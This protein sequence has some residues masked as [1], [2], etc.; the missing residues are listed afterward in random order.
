MDRLSQSHERVSSLC[1]TTKQY[2]FILMHL[3]CTCFYLNVVFFYFIFS[4]HLICR[5][6]LALTCQRVLT[7]TMHY[8]M[9]SYYK[10]SV[11]PNFIRYFQ[12]M[13]ITFNKISHSNG[14]FFILVSFFFLCSCSISLRLISF[15]CLLVT[16][17]TEVLT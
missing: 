16:R 9:N 10:S 7:N 15:Y 1:F 5:I 14:F 17:L 2:K 6:F 4:L 13:F 11:G 3:C 12:V 8:K